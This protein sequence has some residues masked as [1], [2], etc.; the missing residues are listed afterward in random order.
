MRYG[1]L[2]ALALSVSGVASGAAPAAAFAAAELANAAKS[3]LA[4]AA[5]PTNRFAPADPI[6]KS[7]G[8]RGTDWWGR[9]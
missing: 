1:A 6:D 7:W 8:S 5:R 9:K 2:A 3:C 4:G